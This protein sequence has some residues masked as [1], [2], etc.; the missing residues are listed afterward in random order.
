MDGWYFIVN[1]SSWGTSEIIIWMP[2]WA[3]YL[4]I[5]VGFCGVVAI[6]VKLIVWIRRE[7]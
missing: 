6:V 4:S 2:S 5:L 7:R 1:H 3:Y